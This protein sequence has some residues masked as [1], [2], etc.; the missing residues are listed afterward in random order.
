MIL[1]NVGETFRLEVGPFPAHARGAL[2]EPYGPC[3]RAIAEV[4][5][6]TPPFPPRHLAAQGKVGLGC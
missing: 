3:A 1:E 4:G 5:P 2:E 6:P